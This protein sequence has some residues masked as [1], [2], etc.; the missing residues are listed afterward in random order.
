MSDSLREA[1]TAAY[2]SAPKEDPV[3]EII[4]EDVSTETQAPADVAAADEPESTQQEDTTPAV[5]PDSAEKSPPVAGALPSEA[6]PA[7]PVA[8]P[9]RGW[10]AEAK[11]VFATLPEAVRKDVLRR[12]KEISLGLENVA[13][14]RKHYE[15]F[16]EVVKPF[17]PLM[18]AYGV[19]DPL[20]TI[21]NLLQIRAALEV[22]TPEQ[23]SR[24]ISNM[25]YDFGIDI[26]QLADLITE[27]GPVGNSPRPGPAPAFNPRSIPELQPLFDMAARAQQAAVAKAEDAVASI[28]SQPHFEDVR[29][30]M[31]DI[32]E[33]FH[34]AGKSIS[35]EA[36][37]KRALAMNPDLEP[38]PAQ[39]P[40]ITKSQAAAILASRNAASS[41]GGAPRTGAKPIGDDIRSH[42]E[43]AW[44]S[45]R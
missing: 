11:K 10:G 14:I 15:S 13:P 36:A 34:T 1:L 30:D 2:E 5:K 44:N 43:A 29:E 4:P 41:V 37:Y 21:Q 40:Q 23:K 20:P 26:D 3:P 28:E 7:E 12:E 38:A 31:A 42:L 8:K 18:N 17:E 35:I 16:K 27:R 9:P 25:I 22:G 24:L 39:V 45:A 32:I 6:A 19:T 33:R